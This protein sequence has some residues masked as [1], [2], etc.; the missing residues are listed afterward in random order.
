MNQIRLY[1]DKIFSEL[2]Q[3]WNIRKP[4]YNMT[5]KLII[6]DSGPQL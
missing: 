3:K 4:I 2:Q 6:R 1:S 5:G